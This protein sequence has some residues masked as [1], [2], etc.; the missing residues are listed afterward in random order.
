MPSCGDERPCQS[1]ARVHVRVRGELRGLSLMVE[2]R[3]GFVKL[4]KWTLFHQPLSSFPAEVFYFH[5]ALEGDLLMYAF[6]F[7]A[8]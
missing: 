5:F 4:S 8:D 7:L 1:R 3:V 6:R 2:G